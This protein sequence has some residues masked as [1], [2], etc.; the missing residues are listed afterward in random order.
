MIGTNLN[1]SQGQGK[2]AR[3][4]LAS[5]ARQLDETADELHVGSPHVR[6][7]ADKQ[8]ADQCDGRPAIL[9]DNALAGV[10]P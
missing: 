6:V 10:S 3:R 8:V 7:V 4:S 9:I 2:T 1:A 5:G